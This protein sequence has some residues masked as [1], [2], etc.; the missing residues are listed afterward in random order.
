MGVGTGVR[1]A[2]GIG[3]GNGKR[4]GAATVLVLGSRFSD[5]RCLDEDSSLS[6][7]E[8]FGSGTAVFLTTLL[9]SA[10]I[11]MAIGT[12][13]EPP[14]RYKPFVTIA[15]HGSFCGIRLSCTHL[16]IPRIQVIC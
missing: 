16:V 9:L 10:D 13:A 2:V 5:L 12:R 11:L 6:L 15:L 1:T 7:L 14:D 8:Y 3:A 4:A